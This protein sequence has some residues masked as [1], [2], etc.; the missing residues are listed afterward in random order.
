VAEPVRFEQELGAA[1]GAS[2]LVRYRSQLAECRERLR[3]VANRSGGAQVAAMVTEAKLLRATLVLA[4]G[5]PL[6]ASASALV[7]AAVSIELLHLASLVHDDI[8]DEAMERRGVPALHVTI[9]RN[10]ALVVGDV[11]IVAAFGEIGQARAAVAAEV[12]AD[13]VEALSQGAQMCCVGQLDELDRRCHVLSEEHY[14]GIAAKKTGAL[15]SV[16]SSLGALAA[17]AGDEA[18]ATLATF[19]TELGVAYQIRDDLHDGAEDEPWRRHAAA[20][21]GQASGVAQFSPTVVT[22]AHAIDAVLSALDRVPAP[23]ADPL[24]ALAEAMLRMSGSAPE[25][26]TGRRLARPVN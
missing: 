3:D 13:S 25:T 8:I 22:C 19:G 21:P 26:I 23:C 14:L 20:G 6:G 10:R 24:R 16:A 17:G 11:L 1:V 9:G 2:P 4:S 7:P 18:V 12:Y 5:S 15:F